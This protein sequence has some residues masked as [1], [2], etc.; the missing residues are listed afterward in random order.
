MVAALGRAGEDRPGQRTMVEAVEK[1]IAERRHLLVQ[2]GTGTGKSLGYLIPAILSGRRVVVATA[3]KALQDQLVGKD[4]PFLAAHLGVPFSFACL[5]GRSNYLCVQ[6]VRELAAGGQ[7][8]LAIDGGERPAVGRQT[9]RLVTWAG[10]QLDRQGSGDR[11]DLTFEPAPPAW[12]A[13]S[14][15]ARECPG[16]DRCPSGDVCFCERAREEAAAA[17][18]VV[19]NSYLYGMHLASGGTVL[20]EHDLVVID[21]AH[22]LEDVLS[23][24]FGL[25]L[26]ESRFVA[27]GR[28]VRAI[29]ADDRLI[30][31]LLDAGSRLADAMDTAPAGRLRRIDGELADAIV[32]GRARLE[33]ALAALRRIDRPPPEVAPRKERA[34]R[35]VSGLI[36]DL[37]LVLDPPA[38][39]VAWV[40]RG[41]G[42]GPV[43]R[44]APIEVAGYL[45]SLWSET[46]A[47]LTS[48]TLHPALPARL[49]MASGAYEAVDVGS[50][51]DFRSNARLY[52][53]AHLP[54][55]RQPGFEAA[56]HD[57]L[58]A[59]I[60]AA[61][62]RTLA[63]FTSR[64][65]MKAAVE[66]VRPRLAVPVLAQDDL[67][68][69]ALV[70]A[71]AGDEAT[72]LFA[73]MGFWQGID[74]PG[75]SLSLVTIDRLPFTP[76]DDPLT[77]ARREKAGPA[78]F[79]LIDVPRAATLLAQGVG[80]LIRTSVDR[81]VVAVF[82]RRLATGGYRAQILAALPPM[83]RS[84]DRPTVER[85]LR[86]I[87][88]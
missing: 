35:L 34:V 63:L 4:L 38:T 87:A 76:P 47:I 43:L 64:R 46:T 74:V 41:P 79:S 16:A 59:L 26:V 71:F 65:R 56:M 23:V 69:P 10:E 70:A 40:E 58:A 33:R 5:K 84:V 57:E 88:G 85:F 13:V 17:D 24:T 42:G 15:S 36:D 30:A 45:T 7:E 72:C 67:P 6:R 19:V 12:A 50:P 2:A 83:R 32:A 51:F 1:A 55:P 20:P 27:V 82:D 53:A 18:V 28:G 14:V 81:G 37:D 11:A 77:Q 8:E 31:G 25:E 54:D 52:C 48:A 29:V 44:L 78:A 49:G 61:G 3:T 66:A 68:K 75:R 21:E 86:E 73:T 80:R 39:Q 22:G 9:R 62:G 60:A